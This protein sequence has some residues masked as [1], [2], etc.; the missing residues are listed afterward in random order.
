M[1]LAQNKEFVLVTKQ[2][3]IP[4]KDGGD[5]FFVAIMRKL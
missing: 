3:T 4:K 2:T 5:G 1:F